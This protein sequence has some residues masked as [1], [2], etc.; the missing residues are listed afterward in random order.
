MRNC[1]ISVILICF[2][3]MNTPNNINSKSISCQQDLI[4]NLNLPEG[5]IIIEYKHLDLNLKLNRAVL[6][7]MINPEKKPNGS[8]KDGYTC[9]DETCGSCYNGPTRVSLIDTKDS[10]L[11]NTIEV[12]DES[13]EN[14][15]NLDIPYK[16]KSGYFYH[17]NKFKS[18]KEENPTIMWLKDYN[19]DGKALEFALFEKVNCMYLSTTLIGYSEKQDKIIQYPIKLEV[20]DDGLLST[21]ISFWKDNLFNRKPIKA[22]YWKY[23]MDYR[24]RGGSLVKYEIYYNQEA[25][26]FEGTC[27]LTK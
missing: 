2:S 18:K 14:E 20:N 23:E 3:F 17:V 24:G 25:E 1:L 9:P 4:T 19:G 8:P 16:I 6:L 5:A 10:R 13:F 7:W 22:S 21:N 11:I 15:D 12:K 27:V 26:I